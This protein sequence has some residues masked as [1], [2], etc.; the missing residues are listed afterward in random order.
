[1]VVIKVIRYISIGL[2]FILIFGFCILASNNFF[3]A[4]EEVKIEV[5]VKEKDTLWAIAKEHNTPD[6]DIRKTIYRIKELNDLEE[7]YIYPGQ[8]L[9][10][11]VKAEDKHFVQSNR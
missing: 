1:M 9:I 10:I 3:K 6:K 4:N 8:E 7:L 2:I 11:P 5:T